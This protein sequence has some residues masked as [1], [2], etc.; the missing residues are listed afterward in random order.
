MYPL[1]SF[2]IFHAFK[3]LRITK[4]SLSFYL[5]LAEILRDFIFHSFT[6][7]FE[8]GFHR[9]G[10]MQRREFSYSNAECDYI[11]IA[12]P[13]FPL[14]MSFRFVSK[15]FAY[16]FESRFSIP[17][18]GLHIACAEA[19]Q[20]TTTSPTERVLQLQAVHNRG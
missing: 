9:Y 7:P 3:S 12:Q 19:Q 14:A 18:E 11:H 10:D 15:R 2:D 4:A 6:K 1:I 13:L 8:L 17:R 16:A 5:K 20:T